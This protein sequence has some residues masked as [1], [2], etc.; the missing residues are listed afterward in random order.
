MVHFG[1]AFGGRVY[2]FLVC[3]A[4]IGM[5]FLLD[6]TRGKNVFHNVLLSIFMLFA[7]WNIVFMY[8]YMRGIVSR[9]DPVTWLER[10]RATFQIF[11]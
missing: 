3:F 7:C 11:G 6:W 5:A 4:M 2:E 8:L 10:L 1:S 9:E